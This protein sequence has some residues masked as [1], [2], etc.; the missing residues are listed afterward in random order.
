MRRRRAQPVPDARGDEAPR[1]R[2]RAP[3]RARRPGRR[4]RPS[5]QG[6]PRRRPPPLGARPRSGQQKEATSAREENRETRTRFS[7][8]LFW[9]ALGNHPR[10]DRDGR[11]RG[12]GGHGLD[13]V[14]LRVPELHA[15]VVGGRKGALERARAADRDVV[16]GLGDGDEDRGVRARVRG[17]D[18]AAAARE[19]V[20]LEREL[21]R[22]G[23][24]RRG[25]NDSSALGSLGDTP[26]RRTPPGS[27]S[28][29]A[30]L[31]Q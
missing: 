24:G 23:R 31:S 11:L 7:L 4:A 28:R 20:D 2:R 22:G 29:Y 30:L 25:R 10:F 15:A 13:D 6:P 19:R 9:S 5:P 16:R 8:A 18:G 17:G 21:G 1:G 14:L 26:P 3:P 27:R 12:L